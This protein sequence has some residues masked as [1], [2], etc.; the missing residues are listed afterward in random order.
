MDI[1]ALIQLC[2]DLVV[3]GVVLYIIW[4]IIKAIPMLAPFKEVLMAILTLIAVLILASMVMPLLGG[5]GHF[6]GGYHARC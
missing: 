6:G 2:I 5:L 4:I 1:H 3:A